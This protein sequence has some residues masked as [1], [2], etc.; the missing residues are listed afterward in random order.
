MGEV[1][2]R[3]VGHSGLRVSPLGLDTSA[4]NDAASDILATFVDAGGDLVDV[5]PGTEPV[6]AEALHHVGRNNVVL[7]ASA[8]VTMDLPVGQRVNC[9]RTSLLRGLDETLRAL[10]TDF[11]DVFYAGY[12]DPRT[13]AEEVAETLRVAVTAG[14]VRYAGA[15][16]YGGWQLAVTP[17]L[18]VA[19]NDYSLLQ[20]DAEEEQL[21]AANHLGIGV[22]ASSALAGGVLTGQAVHG[23]PSTHPYESDKART[24]VEAL[25]TAAKG[26]D[27]S[28]AA[29]ALA[30]VCGQPGVA[31]VLLSP[32]SI[33]DVKAWLPAAGLVLP[34]PIVSAL[35]DVSK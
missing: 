3:N 1:K 31:S 26:L 24:I 21:P 32:S 10:Q 7:S 27:L 28:P 19:R 12:W 8:G 25:T 4:L 22:I 16:G 11:L 34:R 15:T 14:K 5:Y 18:T 6:A 35:D 30:W 23:N 33:S 13:P 20:R 29:T 17:G 9:S 2:K